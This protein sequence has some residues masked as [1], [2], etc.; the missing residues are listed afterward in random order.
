MG[1]ETNFPKVITIG[2]NDLVRVIKDTSSRN[3]TKK[4]FV[5][6]IGD[7]L[8]ADG[9]LTEDTLP[10][11]VAL[12]R[13]VQT[14]GV[15]HTAVLTDDVLLMDATGSTLTVPLPFAADAFDVA[16][17]K[18]S[19]FTIAKIDSSATNDV[20]IDPAGADLIG[21]NTLVTLSGTLKP[22]IDIVS[23]GSNWN[24]I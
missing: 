9:F 1:K 5:T 13:F 18:G 24:F 12:T 21:G 22:S 17:E 20:I 3:M 23:D 10:P 6:D 4:N 8:I 14:F 2:D 7:L 16:T 15:N 11:S 19:R